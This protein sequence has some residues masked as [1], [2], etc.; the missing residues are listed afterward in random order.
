MGHYGGYTL[1]AFEQLLQLLTTVKGKFM[2]S[3]YPMSIL[4]SYAEK[5]GWK[6]IELDLP[7]AAG[8]GRKI[9]ILTVNYEVKTKYDVAN[10][11]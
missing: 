11:A 6:M 5:T 3:S 9:E 2:L 4:S 10:A 1:D 7:R 8:G